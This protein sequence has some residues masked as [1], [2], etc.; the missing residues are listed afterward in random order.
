[1][2]FN[3]NKKHLDVHAFIKQILVIVGAILLYGIFAGIRANTSTLSLIIAENTG[4][5]YGQVS[6][7]FAILNLV[8]AICIPIIGILTLKIRKFFF[9]LFG[10]ILCASA[11]LGTAFSTT[12]PQLILFI[13]IIFGLGSALFSFTIVFSAAKPFLGEKGSSIFSG[14]LL[15]SQG[16]LGML[17]AQ[18]ITGIT[19]GSG[20]TACMLIISLT[21]VCLI[22]FTFIFLKRKNS[23][24]MTE[25]LQPHVPLSFRSVLKRL[26]H[27]PLF[28]L[29]ILGALAYGMGDGILMNHASRLTMLV[30]T[31][32]WYASTVVS[33]YTIS[34]IAG[35]L[36]GGILG[37]KVKSRSLLLSIC[38]LG[39]VLINILLLLLIDFEGFGALGYFGFYVMIF[40]SGVLINMC[41]VVLIGFAVE[42]VSTAVCAVV[43]SVIDC[44]AFLAYALN[45]FLG[46]LF[47]EIF[48]RFRAIDI[49]IV[50]LCIITGIIFLVLGLKTRNKK[51]EIIT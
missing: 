19:A 18:G 30:F 36:G 32:S 39:W 31:D 47:I 45:S 33:I 1:M 25:E 13:G 23:Q 17:L 41:G 44:G 15:A 20:F 38:F 2:N 51:P 8:F 43:L 4:V 14:F 26:I 6:T 16:I 11:F 24:N 50:L 37:S 49:I 40:T 10:A 22:P 7:A 12:F 28:Y 27:H 42:H 34:V 3:N 21:A 48:G 46:G 29:I 9:L 5:P 35:A